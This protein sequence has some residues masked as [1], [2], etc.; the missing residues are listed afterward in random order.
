MTEFNS[1]QIID[2]TAGGDVSMIPPFA[3]IDRNPADLL[4]DSDDRLWVTSFND[5]VIEITG[6]GD[7]R[8]DPY[9]APND[10]DDLSSITITEMAG[11]LLVGNEHTDQIV[12][13]TDGGNLSGRPVFAQ[14]RGVIGLRYVPATGQLFA[15]SELDDAIYEISAGG[16]YTDGDTPFATGLD[17]FDVAQLLYISSGGPDPD[18]DPDAGPTDAGADP[19]GDAGTDPTGDAGTDPDPDPDPGAGPDG[20]SKKDS[21]GGGC[22][23]TTGVGSTQVLLALFFLLI[24]GR[25]RSSR[26][27]DAGIRDR[28]CLDRS[29]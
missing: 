26:R 27:P 3:R 14:V 29:R 8:G 5:G 10:L 7:F 22:T 4:L 15:A 25:R 23:T 9:Y 28:R 20:G 18:P 2:I 13:F 12:N 6:G 21:G 1:A 19:T 17:P 16:D 11:T 24:A